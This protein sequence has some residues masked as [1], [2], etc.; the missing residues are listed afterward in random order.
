[1]SNITSK[2]VDSVHTNLGRRCSIR[3]QWVNCSM[4]NVVG[5]LITFTVRQA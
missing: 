1:M 2:G 4:Y 3:S 5:S